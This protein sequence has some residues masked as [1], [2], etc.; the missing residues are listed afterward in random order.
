MTDTASKPRAEISGLPELLRAPAQRWLDRLLDSGVSEEEWSTFPGDTRSTLIRLI[1]SSEFAAGVLLREWAWFASAQAAGV[2]AAP[3][4]QVGLSEFAVD[5]GNSGDDAAIVKARLRQFRNR[6][7]IQILW[8]IS[9]GQDGVWDSLQALSDLANCL[10]VACMR[11]AERTLT[12]RFG[13]PVGRDGEKVEAVI[14]AMGKL[15]GGELNFSSDIDLI[16][17]YSGAG[18]TD[19]PRKLSAHE[20][21][22]RFSQ[23][24]V[25]L[26]D[27]VTEDGFVY[28]VDTR[29]RPFGDS[30]PPV[31]SF[32]AL[33]NY[34]LQHG[35]NWERY[36]YV[37]ARIISPSAPKEVITELQTNIID[38]FV[39]RRY[40]DYGVFE[41]LR[42]MKTLIETEV[43]NRELANNIKLGP[44][45]IREI[46]FIAQSLQLVRG[47]ADRE[48]R[49]RA[50]KQALSCLGHARGLGEDSVR[51]LRSAYEFFRRFE[52]AVQAI[53]DQQTHEIPP[54]PVDQARVALVMEHD[55]WDAL[56][57]D[58]NGHRANV[59][60]QFAEVAFRGDEKTGAT[61][62][63]DILSAAWTKSSSEAE[64]TA[65]LERAGYKDAE[66]LASVIAGFASSP[67]QRQIGVAARKRL[68]RFMPSLLIAVRNR[69]RSGIVCERVLSVISRILRRSAYVALLNENPTVLE[70]LVD[71]CGQSEYLSGEIA[72][73][74]ILLDELLD[75]RIYSAQ[76][77]AAQMR[78]DLDDR[79]RQSDEEDSES[80]IEVLAQFQRANLFRIAVADIAGNLPIMK[81]SDGLTELAEI[82]LDEALSVAW[83][84]LTA[85]Y[86]EPQFRVGDEVKTAGFGVI[87]YGKLGGI[88]LSYGSDLDLVFLHNSRGTEQQTNGARPLDNSMF[89]GRLVRRLVHFLTAQTGSGALYEVDTRLRPSGRSGLLVV[90]TDGFEKYQEE[91]A[92]TWEHQALLRSR[93][94]AGSAEVAREFEHI[95]ADT[96]KNRVRRDTLLEDVLSMRRKMREK[97]DKSTAE[98]FDLKQGEGGIGDIEFL[99]QYLVLKNA[100]REPDLIHYSDNIRQLDALK[101]CGDLSAEDAAGL[102]DAYKTFR[103]CNHRHA[104]DGMPPLVAADR[105]ADERAFVTTIWQREM[106]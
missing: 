33:E 105:F 37:K 8:R 49:C 31:V 72:R 89:F 99:V 69:E 75:P 86:G 66:H 80:S 28:R 84:D 73:Y 7:F 43:R 11:Y 64:W 1:A 93:A 103:L 15:G 104:L 12:R 48:L 44:G 23:Q 51:V 27:E 32:A 74:P 10:I 21:Y 92:W 18:E 87:A 39:Y 67:V 25:A 53:R 78:E 85:I 58:L 77:S 41:S 52:N 36:A 70:R 97:L 102:Q 4:D 46:E 63:A 106:S 90:S 62:S 5:I 76:I 26:L 54:D 29:L 40:L 14:L 91:H 47:G 96:L 3:V 13:Q 9:S 17:L 6:K 55:N 59:S 81:V 42:D 68:E 83:K 30:G 60:E 65:V 38:P 95:R 61:E 71:L 82:V 2:F 57:A 50:L 79:L 20:Y 100:D 34:L 45:G 56:L 35:R 19:G 101:A 94:V 22:V 98:L 24:V 16:F 88:E